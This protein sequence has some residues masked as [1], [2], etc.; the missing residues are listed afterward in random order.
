[1]KPNPKTADVE[2]IVTAAVAET[3]VVARQVLSELVKLLREQKIEDSEVLQAIL[4]GFLDVI[5]P[6]GVT[7]DEQVGQ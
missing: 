6:R 1:M 5:A 3:T 7:F 4:K 2:A